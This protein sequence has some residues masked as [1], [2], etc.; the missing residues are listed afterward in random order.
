LN[1]RLSMSNALIFDS[2]VDAGMPSFTAAPNGPDTR[3]LVSASIASI[4]SFSFS[5]SVVDRTGV[6]ARDG[7]GPDRV[8]SRAGSLE[9]QRS[10][11]ESVP[12]SVTMTARSMM[13]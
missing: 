13:F 4:A 6:G 3:P 12:V 7:G 11:I 5:S 9:S 2:R 10:S 1:R 8:D